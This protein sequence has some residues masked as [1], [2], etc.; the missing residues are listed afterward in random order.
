MI[1]EP[2]LSKEFLK[3]IKENQFIDKII[4]EI[5]SGYSTLFFSNHFKFVYS[6]E[7]DIDWFL[8]IDSLIKEKNITNVNISMFDDTIIKNYE[9]IK[10]LQLVDVFLIDNKNTHIAR[11]TF[12][13]VINSN[14]KDESIIVLDNGTWSIDAYRFLRENYYCIDFPYERE[15]GTKTETS[16]F[17]KKIETKNKSKI[18]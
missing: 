11:N 6:F 18:I 9:F 12:A 13:K 4:L 15:D 2:K 8:K 1:D 5:G 14:K 3:W 10:L 17:F 7:D 16:V